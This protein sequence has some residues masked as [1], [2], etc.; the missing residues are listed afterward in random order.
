MPTSAPYTL[1]SESAATPSAP[2]VAAMSLRTR[3]IGSTVIG[4]V[5]HVVTEVVAADGGG[6]SGRRV[7]DVAREFAV[8]V[9]A[10]TPAGG[11][12]VP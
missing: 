10:L 8:K 9:L 11:G 7:D 6:L 1:P 5:S 4:G 3:V 2:L 12:A